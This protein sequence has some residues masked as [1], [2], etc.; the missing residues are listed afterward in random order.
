MKKKKLV[1]LASLHF[2]LESKWII[3]FYIWSYDW[4]VVDKGTDVV[5][6][7]SELRS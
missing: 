3:C 7:K 4:L 1:W 6:V 5:K 2:D